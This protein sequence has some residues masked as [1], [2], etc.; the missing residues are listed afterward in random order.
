MER[1][2]EHGPNDHA[3]VQQPERPHLLPRPIPRLVRAR[4]PGPRAD[5]GARDGRNA[6]GFAYRANVV[7]VRALPDPFELIGWGSWDEIR[8]GINI[9]AGGSKIVNMSFGSVTGNTGVVNAINYW[10]D[11]PGTAGRLFFGAVGTGAD[12]ET[13]VFP[14]SVPAVNAVTGID[15]VTSSHPD[16]NPCG[17]CF[18]GDDVEFS[19]WDNVATTWT[20]ENELARVGGSSGGSAQIT[21][22]AALVWS[23][24]PSWTRGQVL[25]RLR[26]AAPLTQKRNG[27]GYGPPDA[28]LAV[29]GVSGAYV[30]GPSQ[31]QAGLTSSA[32]FEAHAESLDPPVSGRYTY[33][34]S[35]GAT[36]KTVNVAPECNLGSKSVSVTITDTSDGTTYTRSR[37]TPSTTTPATVRLGAGYRYL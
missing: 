28:W 9:A 13:S 27:S 25:T 22:I 10:H 32:T 17:I 29:G 31:V 1:R 15:P 20:D 14:A 36:S 11:L 16:Y 34:W 7:A 2:A 35:T 5:R 21:A 6:V 24:Y 23:R 30:T 8:N 12:S 33:S 37:P 26:Q 3:D 4:E 18:R 19:A